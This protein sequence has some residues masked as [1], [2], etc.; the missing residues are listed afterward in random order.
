MKFVC[1][2]IVFSIPVRKIVLK[3]CDEVTYGAI[4]MHLILETITAA[5]L[6]DI[7]PFTQQQID[8]IKQ[9]LAENYRQQF[10]P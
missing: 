9:N 3:S 6:V 7:D 1:N 10:V 8:N 4:M 5:V 2:L